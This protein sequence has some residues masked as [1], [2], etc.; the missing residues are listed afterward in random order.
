MLEGASPDG[1]RPSCLTWEAPATWAGELLGRLVGWGSEGG[2]SVGL[3]VC[4]RTCVSLRVCAR[5]T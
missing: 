1:A 2:V 4:T 3:C 5:E